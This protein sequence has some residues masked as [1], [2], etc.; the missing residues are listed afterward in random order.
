MREWAVH[1][2]GGTSGGRGRGRR[3]DLGHGEATGRALKPWVE[4]ALS[5]PDVIANR[6]KESEF[7]ADLFAVD[8][9][10]PDPTHIAGPR[11]DARGQGSSCARP[12]RW[13]G[14]MPG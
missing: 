10:E 6:F 5:D 4:V 7:A 9:G 2:T 13:G 11:R 3:L 1:C 8:G 12:R 14:R